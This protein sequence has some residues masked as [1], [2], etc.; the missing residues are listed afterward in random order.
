MEELPK[1]PSLIERLYSYAEFFNGLSEGMQE[2]WYF[3][4]M[5]GK[6]GLDRQ[7]AKQHLEEFLA[8]LEAETKK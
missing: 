4:E 5:E 3:V 7:L 8:V 2:D 6:T 1:D